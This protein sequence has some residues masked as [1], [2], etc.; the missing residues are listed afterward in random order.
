[1]IN[2]KKKFLLS[3]DP[4]I[5]KGKISNEVFVLLIPKRCASSPML[6]IGIHE[7]GLT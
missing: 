6:P 7:V 3:P 1:M 5:R 4:D 2:K